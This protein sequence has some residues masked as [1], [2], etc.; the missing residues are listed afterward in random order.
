MTHDTWPRPAITDI[1]LI[2]SSQH[3][4]LAAAQVSHIGEREDGWGWGKCVLR[5]TLNSAHVTRTTK[6]GQKQLN[7]ALQMTWT[8]TCFIQFLPNSVTPPNAF[9]PHLPPPAPVSQHCALDEKCLCVYVKGK[10]VHGVAWDRLIA[11]PRDPQNPSPPHTTHLC[12]AEDIHKHTQTKIPSVVSQR[13]IIDIWTENKK[14]HRAAG[15]PLF[16]KSA[17]TL[18]P[19]W[20]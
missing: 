17:L 6:E 13:E 4:T 15:S 19:T 8:H 2:V 10:V 1:S 18:S 7:G 3:T 14:T 20:R 5:I 11:R 9:V 16:A 12:Y